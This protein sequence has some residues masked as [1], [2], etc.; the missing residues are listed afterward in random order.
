METGLRPI[1]D[2]EFIILYKIYTYFNINDLLIQKIIL[3]TV[4]REDLKNKYC[5][6]FIKKS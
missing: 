1:R 4:S 5:K 6:Y 3:K 2:S